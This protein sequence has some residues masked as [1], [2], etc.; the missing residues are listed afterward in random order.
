MA[1]EVATR[2]QPTTGIRRSK[3]NTSSRQP[4]DM[5]GPP[6][7]THNHSADL[8]PSHNPSQDAN[9]PTEPTADA[10]PTESQV[11]TQRNTQAQDDGEESTRESAR[12]PASV[13]TQSSDSQLSYA[14]Q[15]GPWA[16][17]PDNPEKGASK[18]QLRNV[19]LRLRGIAEDSA[20]RRA[21]LNDLR[22]KLDEQ[23]KVVDRFK[24]DKATLKSR[25]ERMDEYF[26]YWQK[27][28]DRWSEEPQDAGGPTGRDGNVLSPGAEP[29]APTFTRSPGPGLGSSWARAPRKLQDRSSTLRAGQSSRAPTPGRLLKPVLRSSEYAKNNIPQRA[30]TSSRSSPLEPAIL[31]DGPVPGS[32][33]GPPRRRPRSPSLEYVDPPRDLAAPR[34]SVSE[35]FSSMARRAPSPEARSSLDRHSPPSEPQIRRDDCHEQVNG[36]GGRPPSTQSRHKRCSPPELEPLDVPLRNLPRKGSP[37]QEPSSRRSTRRSSREAPS[38]EKGEGSSIERLRT[39]NPEPAIDLPARMCSG[40]EM[41]SATPDTSDARPRGTKRAREDSPRNDDSE[42]TYAQ[43]K[44]RTLSPESSSRVSVDVR[45]SPE[46]DIHTREGSREWSIDSIGEETIVLSVIAPDLSVIVEDDDEDDLSEWSDAS[47]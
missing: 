21:T 9:A 46:E 14:S 17:L 25:R 13:S 15:F 42:N 34:S 27:I 6:L 22:K 40:E 23:R 39:I 31:R 18:A 32:S 28:P 41:H 2:S 11:R 3:R 10:V 30:S 29:S 38:E 12:G 20:K 7:Y 47:G 1:H 35:L 26:T 4:K 24:R 19:V 16:G 37:S 5:S 8:Q 45:P 33:D 43:K 44:P 36:R